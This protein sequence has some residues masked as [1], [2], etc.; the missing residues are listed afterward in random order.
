MIGICYLLKTGIL[1]QAQCLFQ[2]GW[3]GQPHTNSDT[4]INC[5]T[6]TNP[7]SVIFNAGMTGN[8]RKERAIKGSF[9]WHPKY[10]ETC[11]ISFRL[12]ATCL[13]GNS[14]MSPAIG[15]GSLARTSPSLTT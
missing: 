2:D 14:D 12:W 11:I 10:L 6:S 1:Q 15:S 13:R 4:C 7:L 5:V 3:K 9:K 8:A